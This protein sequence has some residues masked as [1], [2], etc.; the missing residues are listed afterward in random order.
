[1]EA[2]SSSVVTKRLNGDW[3]ITGVVQQVTCLTE[4]RH[5]DSRSGGTVSIDCSGI[6]K[7][8]LSGIELL[9]TWL[10]CI[11]LSGRRPELLNIPDHMRETGKYQGSNELKKWSGRMASIQLPA[12]TTVPGNKRE[13]NLKEDLH[14]ETGRN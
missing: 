7:I 8:D 9:G 12:G 5:G 13:A 11:Q 2:V 10:H 4:S 6:E 1:M 3:T 14:Y